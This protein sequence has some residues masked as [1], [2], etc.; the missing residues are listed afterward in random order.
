LNYCV[1]GVSGATSYVW[2]LPQGWT[3]NS[4]STSISA[5]AG[6]SGS[7]TV[8]AANACGNSNPSSLVVNITA[9]P[10]APAAISGSA[11]VCAGEVLSYNVA[12]V[13]GATSYNWV[14]PSGWN[15]TSTTNSI[16][17]T[18]GNQGGTLAVS[19]VNACGA[20]SSTSLDIVF[21][22]APAAPGSIT[23]STGFC[24]GDVIAYSIDPVAGASGYVWTLPDGWTGTSNGTSIQVTAGANA[25]VLTV[26]AQNSCGVGQT[27][28]LNVNLN[29][30]L[31]L[32]GSISGLDVL[33]DASAQTYSIAPV[34]GALS[35]TWTLPSGWTGTSSSESILV[36]PSASSGSLSVVAIGS[37]GAS[38]AISKAVEVV[39]FDESITVVDNVLVA[40]ENNASYQWIN[41]ADNQPILGETG[42]SL[43]VFSSGSYA[44][45]LSRSGCTTLTECVNLEI[46]GINDPT[47]LG[48]VVF[49]NPASQVLNYRLS[50][51]SLVE[52]RDARGRVIWMGMEATEG[53]IDVSAW[54][55]GVYLLRT[56]EGSVKRWIKE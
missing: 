22:N 36:Q 53:Q 47:D 31:T 35:Y 10:S 41:C 56:A 15:G 20:S 17:V 13:S 30:S 48:I 1:G 34:A 7:V 33:C 42:A 39:V 55:K 14:L 8:S 40:N 25:G 24:Q 19:A 32:T 37:C 9:P 2:T 21:G 18:T 11:S 12:S 46:T 29:S 16:T 54:S 44:V 6:T 4:S 43:S 26:A 50:Q 28:T 23:G 52:V 3:G 49:P 38:N 5:V 51:P 45:Q 27:S